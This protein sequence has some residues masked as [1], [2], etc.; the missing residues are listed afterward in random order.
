LVVQASARAVII[1]ETIT[2]S[3]EIPS[4][5]I[6]LIFCPLPG[7]KQS[8]Q[9]LQVD[10][11]LQK[12]I[13][14]DA[15]HAA[16]DKC[17]PKAQSLL[18]VDDNPSAVRMLE[19]MVKAGPKSYQLFRAYNGNDALARIQAQPPDALVLDLVMPGDGNDGY[20]LISE[21]KNNP[22][23]AGLPIIV[24]SGQAVEETWHGKTI[25]IAAGERGFSPT[26]TLKYL[27]GLVSVIPPTPAERHATVPVLSATH[28]A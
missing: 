3:T 17:A 6:P 8:Q 5:S 2:E 28:P 11:Y 4:L 10:H 27:Q 21:L 1:N 25:T 14:T 24:A 22:A 15:L 19:Q 13:T 7:P 18:I 9:D 20:W 26:E 23:T 16:L 12:P